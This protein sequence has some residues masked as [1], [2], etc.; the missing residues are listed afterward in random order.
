MDLSFDSTINGYSC[1]SLIDTGANSNFIGLN[2]IKKLNLEL[3]DLSP[4]E[5]QV[6]LGNLTQQRVLGI[7][8]LELKFNKLPSTTY[9]EAFKVLETM[10]HNIAILGIPFLNRQHVKLDFSQY[11]LQIDRDFLEFENLKNEKETNYDDEIT[12]KIYSI[13]HSI[14]SNITDLI[15]HAKLNNP[16]LG[17]IPINPARIRLKTETA[18]L[19]AKPYKIAYHLYQQ[20]KSEVKRLIDQNVI[21]PSTSTIV[22]LLCLF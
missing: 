22:R 5:S 16:S 9:K 1:K 20:V 17:E 14:D 3:H 6:E 18:E 12:N 13:K 10:D 21:E 2:L 11:L 4:L 7:I 15:R 19:P 8:S